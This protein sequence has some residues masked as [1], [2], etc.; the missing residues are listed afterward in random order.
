MS[1]REELLGRAVDWFMKN[2]V[3][4]TSL[5]TV[6]A[7]IGSSHRMLLYH[8]GSRE[9]L[10]AAV[11]D[12]TWAAQAQ[13]LEVM[14][15]EGR[16]PLEAGRAF[17]KSLA[18]EAQTFGPLF[19]ELAAAAMH[20][21]EWAASLRTWIGVWNERLTQY[22]VRIGHAPERAAAIAHTAL[23]LARGVLFELALGGDRERA[24]A[25]ILEFLESSAEPQR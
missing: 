6:A 22:Y 8:F 11:V 19:F 3:G 21:H 7:G 13:H 18:D 20:G 25:T 15:D 4:D 16:D 24:D 2:G 1:A 17:W 9:G 12:V 5:R 10:L 23:A 14:L